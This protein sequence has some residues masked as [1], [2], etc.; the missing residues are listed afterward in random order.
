MAKSPG[1]CRGGPAPRN[2][3]P[4]ET[5]TTAESPAGIGR[6]PPAAAFENPE[7]AMAVLDLAQALALRL[8]DD[9]MVWTPERAPT[10]T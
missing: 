5:V 2:R 3:T 7:H 1:S 6:Y 10:W 9:R 4:S 8:A